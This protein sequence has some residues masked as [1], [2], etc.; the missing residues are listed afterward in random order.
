MVRFP[1]RACFFFFSGL[2]SSSDTAALALV[3]VI[4]RL[5]LMDNINFSQ[6]MQYSSEEKV[7]GLM[8]GV[9]ISRACGYDGASNKII[10]LCSEGLRVI[11][12]ILL[13][14]LS[15]LLSTRANVS[16]QILFLFLKLTTS[17]LK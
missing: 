4:T 6:F 3:T 17:H 8:K 1:L 13:I 2:S 12:L 10:K 14:C 7:L 15:H 9:D 11:L 5:L 16:L